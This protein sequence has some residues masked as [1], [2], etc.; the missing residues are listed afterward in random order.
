MASSIP[1]AGELSVTDYRRLQRELRKIDL[2][3]PLRADIVKIS[4]PLVKAIKKEIPTNSRAPLSHMSKEI[5]KIGRLRWG[6]NKPSNSAVLSTKL[7]TRKSAALS[8]AKVVVGSAATVMAD[9][10]GKSNKYTN[11]RPYAKGYGNNAVVVPTGKYAGQM[12]YRYNLY[13]P[14]TGETSYRG[15]IHKINNQGKRMIER[16]GR[17]PSRYVYRAADRS[18]PEVRKEMNNTLDKYIEI[19]N[20]KLSANE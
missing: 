10:A 1:S 8:L 4:A 13:N 7:P 5:N 12:G 11:M 3:K 19:V 16:L 6:G 15:R 2:V 17:A 14:K 18:L 9:M 20:K